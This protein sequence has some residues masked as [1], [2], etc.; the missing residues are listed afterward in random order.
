MNS[1]IFLER[2]G[3]LN[4][5]RVVNRQPS[6]PMRFDEFR[7]N[8][9]AL[10]PL[11]RLRQANFR[12]IAITNQPGLSQGCLVRRELEKMHDLLRERF[13]LDDILVCP[14]DEFDGCLCRKPRPGLFREAA[15]KWHL[16]LD[17]CY[18]ISDKWTDALAAQNIGSTSLLVQSPWTG[19]VHHDCVL[20]SI[21]AAA[22]KVL[23]LHAQRPAMLIP[24]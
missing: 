16:D 15:F 19:H 20:S 23:A 12:I 4:L 7:F 17:Q 24:A 2:D 14:H 3:I 1:G 6:V 21:G 18:V 22:N 9:E 8:P 10:E 5:V 11:R 13:K